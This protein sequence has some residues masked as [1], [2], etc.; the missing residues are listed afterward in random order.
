MPKL[1]KVAEA[2][3]FAKQYALHPLQLGSPFRSKPELV[4]IITEAIQPKTEHI[5]EFGPGDGILT[6]KLL[7]LGY[8]VTAVEINKLFYAKLASWNE[9][10]LKTVSGNIS[11]LNSLINSG[12][13][14]I[15]DCLINGVPIGA[16]KNRDSF[17][18]QVAR[19]TKGKYIHYS[20]QDLTKKLSKYFSKA[21]SKK[22]GTRRLYTAEMK[23]YTRIEEKVNA[24]YKN[25]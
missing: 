6:R 15:A 8:K 12:Q 13:I 17:F 4:E 20:I 16:I 14:T 21:I 5:I 23:D 10:N 1:R 7:N 3:R 11:E 9:P 18:T 2:I 24:T 25:C 22:I 19:I